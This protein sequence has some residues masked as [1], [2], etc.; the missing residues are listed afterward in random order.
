V[1]VGG[2]VRLPGEDFMPRIGNKSDHGTI[3]SLVRMT[4]A[5]GLAGGHQWPDHGGLSVPDKEFGFYLDGSWETLEDFKTEKCHFS[6][7]IKV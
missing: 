3:R 4:A 6:I 1:G 7:W 5:R 2:R